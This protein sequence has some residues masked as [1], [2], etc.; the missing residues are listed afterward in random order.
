M[1]R[2]LPLSPDNFGEDAGVR[3]GTFSYEIT[4]RCTV[5]DAIALMSDFHRHRGL[6]PYLVDV[7]DLPPAPGAVR[8]YAIR[9]R[10]PL[11]P[12]PF[13]ITYH[14][15]IVA[16]SDHEVITVARQRPRTTLRNHTAVADNGDGTVHIRAT[17]T[18]QTPKPL[19]GYAF[20]QAKVVHRRLAERL[21]ETLDRSGI[22]DHRDR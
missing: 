19:F 12:F 15:D 22:D 2:T 18:M 7:R 6:N 14:A 5:A 10:L 8:S 11:G 13:Y 17:I 3:E 20:A 21:T 16:L 1:P 4:A 9:D